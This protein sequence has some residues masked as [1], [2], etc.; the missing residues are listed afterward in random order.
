MINALIFILAFLIGIV[1]YF[2]CYKVNISK[3]KSKHIGKK[4]LLIGGLMVMNHL[5]VYVLNSSKTF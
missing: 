3:F 4:I 1:M 2:T 5:N